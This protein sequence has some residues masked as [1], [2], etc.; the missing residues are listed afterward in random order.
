MSQIDCDE[1]SSGSETGGE[2]AVDNSIA[3]YSTGDFI[4]RL[5]IPHL[6]TLLV[7]KVGNE[8]AGDSQRYLAGSP[9][10]ELPT[11]S[12]QFTSEGLTA[13]REEIRARVHESAQLAMATSTYGLRIPRSRGRR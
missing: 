2:S 11:T 12:N 4:S 10:E 9:A 8:L 6:L 13:K 1:E 7:N 5:E 3:D